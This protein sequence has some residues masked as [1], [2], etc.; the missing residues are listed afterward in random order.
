[1]YHAGYVS[2]GIVP[3]A[4]TSDLQ[5]ATLSRPLPVSRVSKPDVW[6]GRT[7]SRQHKRD[8]S[9]LQPCVRIAS[10]RG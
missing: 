7:G 1:M 5:G 3:A 4:L 8:C 6:R 9:D 2:R 10:T